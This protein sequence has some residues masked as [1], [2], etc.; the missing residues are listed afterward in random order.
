[1]YLITMS[2][3]STNYSCY[4]NLISIC[5]TIEAARLAISYK[6]HD[7]G[8]DATDFKEIEDFEKKWIPDSAIDDC[9][10]SVMMDND[11]DY[12]F[13]IYNIEP[14]KI[15]SICLGGYEE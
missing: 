8:R 5:E 1:M 3:R 10:E 7:L 14:D 9:C 12:I 13:R 6:I 2:D 4:V 11:K 15:Y